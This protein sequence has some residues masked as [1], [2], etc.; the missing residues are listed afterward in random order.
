[1]KIICEFWCSPLRQEIYSEKY[2]SLDIIDW[3]DID[4][5]KENYTSGDIW[6]DVFGEDYYDVKGLWKV[7]VELD[8]HFETFYDWEG[9]PDCEV[10]YNPKVVYKSQCG[11]WNELRCIWESLTE[12]NN[13]RNK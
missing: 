11:N 3:V 7:V 8:T 10:H 12:Q 1:M 9:I 4:E 6:Y 2:V 5:I 13:S